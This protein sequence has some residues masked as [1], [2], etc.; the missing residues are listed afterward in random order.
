MRAI[1]LCKTDEWEFGS[2]EFATF[3]WLQLLCQEAQQ[4][5]LAAYLLK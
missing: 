1:Y 3:I 5:S 4:K 2:E